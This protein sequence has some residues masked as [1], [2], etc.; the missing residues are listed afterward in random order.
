[1]VPHSSILA[2]RIPR[3]E[4]LGG[5]QSTHSL[6]CPPPAQAEEA[7]VTIQKDPRP[8]HQCVTDSQDTGEEGAFPALLM[9]PVFP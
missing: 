1:M 8:W 4:E 2:W 6:C 9:R 5:L 3:A 7:K